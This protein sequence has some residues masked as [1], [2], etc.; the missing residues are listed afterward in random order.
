MSI[1]LKLAFVLKPLTPR[2]A[3]ATGMASARSLPQDPGSDSHWDY[4]YCRLCS[5]GERRPATRAHRWLVWLW[6]CIDCKVSMWSK[7]QSILEY[8]GILGTFVWDAVRDPCRTL[9]LPG[10]SCQLHATYET[11]MQSRQ[12][13]VS[14]ADVR[15][16]VSSNRDLPHLSSFGV[17][18][19][20]NISNIFITQIYALRPFVSMLSHHACLPP[21]CAV[22]HWLD[23]SRVPN[24]AQIAAPL[25]YQCRA[26]RVVLCCPG[27]MRFLKFLNCRNLQF[28]TQNIDSFAL[29]RCELRTWS[30]VLTC[31]KVI[32]DSLDHIH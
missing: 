30:S 27:A 7:V 31:G 2:C 6:L 18:D 11:S 1:H 16:C 19:D 13:Q 28:P 9:L 15:G 3:S 21:S 20:E 4:A 22:R 25:V 29:I 12:M 5:T 17:P 14:L 32:W 24:R 10:E 8:L 26:C 23:G